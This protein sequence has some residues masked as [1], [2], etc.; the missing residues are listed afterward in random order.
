M[1]ITPI[2]RLNKLD[3]SKKANLSDPKQNSS[4]QSYYVTMTIYMA[5]R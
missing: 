5:V 2:Y 4:K 3:K 1:G